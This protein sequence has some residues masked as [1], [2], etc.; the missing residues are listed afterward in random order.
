MLT[1]P[2]EII[3]GNQS[4]LQAFSSTEFS[5]IVKFFF[6]SPETNSLLLFAISDL[7]LIA[8]KSTEA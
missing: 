2:A 6:D 8:A 5:I 4:L 3:P 7:S 1:H